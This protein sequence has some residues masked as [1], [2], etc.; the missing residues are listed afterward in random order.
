[1]RIEHGGEYAL[2]GSKGGAPEHPL[3]VH[4]LR[5]DPAAVMVQDGPEPFDAVV[6]ELEGEERRIWWDRAVEAYP[7]YAEYQQKTDRLIPV[8]LAAPARS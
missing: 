6:R 5:A 3:W 8:F 4:N 1:M 2:V 7:P